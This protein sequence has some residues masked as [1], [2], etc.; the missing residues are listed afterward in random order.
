MIF[1]TILVGLCATIP[2][3]K[4]A[5]LPA[6]DADD[7]AF[8]IFSQT[9]DGD[10]L[11]TNPN[12]SIGAPVTG[13]FGKRA[14]AE[15][16]DNH[17]TT[18]QNQEAYI[19]DCE[20]I[21]QRLANSNVRIN[22]PPRRSEEFRSNQF[23]CKIII[24]NQSTCQ[25]YNPYRATLGVAAQSTMDHCPNLSQNSGWGFLTGIS[26]LIYIVEPLDISPPTYSPA[27]T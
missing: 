2:L 12:I 22:L 19:D 25:T 6:V 26:N 4:A 8:E 18:R 5:A 14:H 24:R 15:C 11:V 23:R 3:A 10:E 9:Y 21:A 27:C 13:T 16:W 1:S 17:M 20:N 7:S